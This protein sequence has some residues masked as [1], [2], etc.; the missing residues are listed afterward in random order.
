[1]AEKKK[2]ETKEAAPKAAK[3]G[4]KGKGANQL[5]EVEAVGAKLANR[6]PRLRNLYR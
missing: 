3:G 6:P 5:F 4:K 1:M 2:K